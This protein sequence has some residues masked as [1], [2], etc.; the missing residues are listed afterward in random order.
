[1]RDLDLKVA[2]SDAAA[3]V[4]AV[5]E[6]KQQLTR[7][8]LDNTRLYNPALRSDANIA[9]FDET[10]FFDFG[11]DM[12]GMLAEPMAQERISALQYASK[13]PLPDTDLNQLLQIM[14]EVQ[15]QLDL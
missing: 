9:L 11:D 8:L 7:E 15:E 10:E 6:Q 2:D 3:M 14:H 13:H 1:L 4:S 12:N 5:A